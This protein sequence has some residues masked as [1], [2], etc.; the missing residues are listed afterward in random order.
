MNSLGGPDAINLYGICNRHIIKFCSN[1]CCSTDYFI[2]VSNWRDE[3]P[4][5]CQL[6]EKA[7]HR[8]SKSSFDTPM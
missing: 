8:A 4:I 1:K 6:H 2:Q 7:F 5:L 3:P